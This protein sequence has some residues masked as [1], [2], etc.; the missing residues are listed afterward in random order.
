MGYFK[1]VKIFTCARCEYI[2][3]GERKCPMCG[4]PGCYRARYLYGSRCY[5]YEKTQLMWMEKKL[6]Y[7]KHLLIN[8]IE[9]L[10]KQQPSSG[11]IN[12]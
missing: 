10:N 4:Y 5:S 1:M 8:K 3:R 12:E 7:Y 9:R 11:G 6:A 2:F